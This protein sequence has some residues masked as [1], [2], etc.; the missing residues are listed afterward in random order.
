M[1]LVDGTAGGLRV[2]DKPNWT[3][4]ALA[5][6]RAQYPDI[7]T[8]DELA[9]TGVYV[10]IGD[11]DGSVAQPAIYVGEADLLR[12]RLD[13]QQT[14]DFWTRFVAFASKDVSLN[15]AHARY[16]EARLVALAT[17]AKRAVVQNG[18]VPP[19]PHL[20][21]SETADVETFLD[22]MLV[23]FPLMGVTAFAS[24]AEIP[25]KSPALHLT[26]PDTAAQGFDTS[27]G[28]RVLAGATARA[29]T[30]P[31]IH[32]YLA[33]KRQEM[34]D[35]GLLHPDSGVLRLTQDYVFDSPSQAAAILLG[36]NANGRTEWVDEQ[37][38]TLKSIQE[39]AIAHE[40]SQGPS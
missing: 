20:S 26:G 30:V 40:A 14:K 36:R 13:Q 27:E 28:F 24:P 33:T 6:S 12:K 17:Q 39:A 18:N 16:L 4:V 10:L 31:S 1:Y 34:R 38:N 22:E 32:A 2:V 15:K 21:E 3:G 23:L 9:R 37:G 7:R 19:S 35:A 29:G 25:S 5:C 11:S 8:R